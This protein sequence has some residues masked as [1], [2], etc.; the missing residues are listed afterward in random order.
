M[1]VQKKLSIEPDGLIKNSF[2]FSK[3][4]TIGLTQLQKKI[5]T[6]IKDEKKPLQ[7]I[8][9]VLRLIFINLFVS[10]TNDTQ[11]K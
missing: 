6:K 10:S 2:F 8:F 7:P 11:I 3:K 5:E 4:T 9:V 1:T